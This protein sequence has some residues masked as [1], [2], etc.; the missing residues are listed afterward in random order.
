MGPDLQE[1]PKYQSALKAGWGHDLVSGWQA[2]K[3]SN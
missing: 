2:H 1:W 3:D